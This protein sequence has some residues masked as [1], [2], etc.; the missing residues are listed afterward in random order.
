MCHCCSADFLPQGLIK[1]QFRDRLCIRTNILQQRKHARAC[2]LPFLHCEDRH[3]VQDTCINV[4]NNGA[5]ASET[6]PPTAALALP[7]PKTHAPP[8]AEPSP[9]FAVCCGTHTPRAPCPNT[10]PKSR[11]LT[12]HNTPTQT[13]APES[14][15][16]ETDASDARRTPVPDM[17]LLSPLHPVQPRA[18]APAICLYTAAS[19]S[20]PQSFLAAV[21]DN[22]RNTSLQL[23][24][25]ITTSMTA[26]P[27]IIKEQIE[28]IKPAPTPRKPHPCPPQ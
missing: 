12:S 24:T 22:P 14:R 25:G 13:R 5:L 23:R 21:V 7:L 28:T 17:H 15:T 11:A 26:A 10:L 1:L 16:P 3:L 8:C 20:T 2:A 9:P 18:T 27:L 6:P 19:L 4:Q